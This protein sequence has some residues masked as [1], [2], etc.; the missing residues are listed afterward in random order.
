MPEY[1]VS[2][3]R[4]QHLLLPP[5]VRDWLPDDHLAWLVLEAVGELNLGALYRAYRDDGHGRAAHDPA[6]MVALLGGST[7]VGGATTPPP[8]GG[9]TVAR[10]CRLRE[11]PV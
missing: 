6:M 2:C 1:F 5:S 9:L 3:D 10:I 7:P 11:R 4:E 8:L